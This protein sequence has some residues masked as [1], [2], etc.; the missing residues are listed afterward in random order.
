MT[1]TGEGPAFCAPVRVRRAG[2][3]DAAALL[4]CVA[5]GERGRPSGAALVEA[6]GPAPHWL[7]MAAGSMGAVGVLQARVVADEA[8]VVDL[9]VQP[10]WRRAGV[11]RALLGY[12]LA[13]APALGVRA[14]WLEV[15]R[16]NAAARALYTR[17]GFRAC[18][19]RRAYYPASRLDDTPACGAAD[20]GAAATDALVLTKTV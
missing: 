19:V 14:V 5:Q 12:L 9:W 4:A 11:G 13:E 15:A 7:A 2:P 8:E 16:G 3:Q 17:F 20:V 1:P 6:T 10:S 18:G